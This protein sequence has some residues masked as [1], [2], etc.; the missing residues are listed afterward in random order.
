MTLDVNYFQS[1]SCQVVPATVK[2]TCPA[3]PR[4][5]GDL[6]ETSLHQMKGNTSKCVFCN[7]SMALCSHYKTRQRVVT[8]LPCLFAKVW[9]LEVCLETGDGSKGPCIVKQN[10]LGFLIATLIRS[11]CICL[12]FIWLPQAPTL[13]QTTRQVQ[14]DMTFACAAR[15][16]GVSQLQP[17]CPT[18]L[19]VQLCAQADI[20]S[21]LMKVPPLAISYTVYTP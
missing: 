11:E 20:P 7:C 6:V 4:G 2:M 10:S 17:G 5:L 1:R 9:S 16:P 18:A 14:T 8:V 15:Q 12:F 19:L 21:L 3:I 13:R